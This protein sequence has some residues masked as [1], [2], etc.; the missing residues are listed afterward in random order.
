MTVALPMFPLNSVLYPG[1]SVPLHVFEDRYRAL[2]H[3]L[4]RIEDPAERVFGTVAIREGYEVGDHGAQSLY[5]VGVR[6]QLTEVEAHPDGSFDI[7]AL[8]RDRIRL[9]GLMTNG[10]FPVGEVSDR[11]A[12]TVDVPEDVLTRARATFTAYRAAVTDL[13]GD[14]YSGLLPKDAEYL[15]WTLAAVAP[16]PLAER[17]T[18]LEADDAGERIAL[19]TDYLRSELEA[20]NVIPSLPATE[21]ARTRWS[22][23]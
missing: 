18:L 9:D 19:V 8:G 3:H 12:P 20:I 16:L 2:V 13:R 15:S 4:L 1:V 7:V 5:R 11:P 6:L 21:V 14:P 22:P 10:E 17:Q 23:N